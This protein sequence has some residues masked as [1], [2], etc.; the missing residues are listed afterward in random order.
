MTN[1]LKYL[2]HKRIP[3]FLAVLSAFLIIAIIN[4]STMIS[5]SYD[6]YY[7]P[8]MFG[9]FSTIFSVALVFLAMFEFSFKMRK[10]SID[11]AYSFPLKR[12]KFYLSRFIIGYLEAAIPLVVTYIISM[13]YLKIKGFPY[14][15]NYNAIFTFLPCLLILGLLAYGF[16]VFFYTQAN[17]LIDGVATVGL[18]LLAPIL[19][20][21]ALGSY[22]PMHN[23]HGSYYFIFYP[24]IGVTEAFN[25]AVL[26]GTIKF[27][28][29]YAFDS[30][31]MV[32]ATIIVL[33]VS[34]AAT[35]GSYF[36]PRTFDSEK[37]GQVSES[38]Y[39]YKILLPVLLIS[40][41]RFFQSSI[42]TGLMVVVTY[43]G[44]VLYRRSF[45]LNLKYWIVFGSIAAAEIIILFIN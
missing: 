30:S 45:K 3:I 12:E 17:N 41:S 27:S 19:L 6:T 10:V 34:L 39:C 24:I 38:W 11:Q 43:F 22:G 33:V 8:Q 13:M 7:K 16:V 4:V 1:Y 42:I 28:F 20:V 32:F 18:A 37:C 44:Y 5:N 14:L 25:E 35:I 36:T 2:L 23:S 40:T 31:Y 15:I 9:V 21:N 26:G 29:N